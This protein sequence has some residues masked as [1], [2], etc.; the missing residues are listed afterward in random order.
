MKKMLLAA[1]GCAL[2]LSACNSEPTLKDFQNDRTL[3]IKTAT[4]CP[5][6]LKK[7]ADDKMGAKDL[8][9]LKLKCSL[10]SKA[11]QEFIGKRAVELAK[12]PKELK[13]LNE[14]CNKD[15]KDAVGTNPAPDVLQNYIMKKIGEDPVAGFDCFFAL[16]PALKKE[17]AMKRALAQ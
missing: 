14:K 15:L 12:N 9:A 1:T 4:A 5:G 13:E 7:A 11:Y 6:D 2:L 8:A 10:A 16:A 3:T 17:A